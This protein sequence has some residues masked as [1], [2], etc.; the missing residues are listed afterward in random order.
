MFTNI[1]KL[2]RRN[3]CFFKGSKGLNTDSAL[4]KPGLKVTLPF[5]PIMH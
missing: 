2:A 1:Y 3:Q 5:P 4:Q